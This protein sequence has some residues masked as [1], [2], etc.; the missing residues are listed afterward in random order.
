MKRKVGRTEY[1]LI[2]SVRSTIRLSV[3]ESGE[4]RVY[5][6]KAMRLRDVDAFVSAHRADVEQMEGRVRQRQQLFEAGHPLAD[7]EKLLV[8]GREVTLRVRP[9]NA[10]RARLDGD[11]L[12]LESPQTDRASLRALIRHALSVEEVALIRGLIA[13]HA[14]ALGV[15]PG[16]IAIREQKSRWG[17]CSSR[18]NLNFNWKLM[19]APPEALEYVVV[20]ELCHLIEFNHS[21]RFWRLVE[22]RMPEYEGAKKWLKDNGA[23]LEI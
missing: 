1:T 7:G 9:S 17:S 16:R 19:L 10:R 20:H 14:P 18:G 8:Q 2:Q 22:S 13:V 23:K 6:P 15:S 11:E 21:A 3:N 4:V 5:A 12:I